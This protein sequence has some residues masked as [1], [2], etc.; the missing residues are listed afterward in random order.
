MVFLTSLQS[1]IPIVLLIALGYILKGRGMFN[2]TFSSNL[3][4]LIMSVIL[5]AG[6]FVSVLHHMQTSD[7]WDLRYG[8]LV[9]GLT[10]F[11]SYIVAFIMMKILR[12]PPGR[13]GIFINM[14]VNDNCLF[15]GLPVQ[16][17]LFGPEA[18]PY[19]LL[20]YIGNTISV[21]MVGVFLI[22]I[23]PLPQNSS[24]TG[25][26]V[27]PSGH[28]FSWK[29][30]LPP[31]LMGFIVALIFLYA[32][33]PLPTILHNTLNYLGD[34]V[35]PLSLLYI[36]IVLHDA[37][38]KSMALNK[39]S[40][41]GIFGRFVIAPLIMFGVII[42]VRYIGGITLEPIAMI[43]FIVQSAGPVI[44]VLPIVA[45][46]SGADLPFATGLVMISTILFVFVIPLIMELLTML[47]IVA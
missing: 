34:M 47:G 30:L 26:S 13:R 24:A 16:I 20:Y 9:V 3:S 28:K 11:V 36:G 33:I 35:T 15:I 27:R 7:L 14:V 37:G 25:E 21:W 8:L 5:P 31:P 19:F 32:Q 23:D 12:V 18:L 44:A 46:E 22:E 1:I 39:D 45:N 10:Y 40:L 42:T 43:T 6:V 2:D 17:A 38:L 29:K 4:R 41:G